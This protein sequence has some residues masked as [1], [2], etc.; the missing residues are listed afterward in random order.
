MDPLAWPLRA[1]DWW[2]ANPWAGRVLGIA[3]VWVGALVF[4]RY[5][6]RLFRELDR[7]VDAFSVSERTLYHIDRIM[8]AATFII[9]GLL[10]LGILGVGEAIYGALT[11]LG[12]I[13][14]VIG[15]ASQDIVKNMFAGVVILLERPFMPG[16]SIEVSGTGGEVVSV[17]LRST[18]LKTWDGRQVTLPNATFISSNIVNFSTNPTRRV[19]APVA[20]LHESDADRAMAI[21]RDIGMSD[22]DRDPTTGVDV[23]VNE[24]R[25]YALVMELRF[26]VPRG[27]L[28]AAKTR[29]FVAITKR[30]AAEGIELAVPLRRTLSITSPANVA[31]VEAVDAGLG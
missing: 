11:A 22:P 17:S 23:R 18:Q 25:E 24:V 29:T 2:Q 10:T 15:F 19:E 7:R 12:I 27:V 9:A 5:N 6:A 13:G 21:L 1:I 26:W 30:F 20:I 14:L 16:D 3:L 8:D 28:I 4:V 31:T